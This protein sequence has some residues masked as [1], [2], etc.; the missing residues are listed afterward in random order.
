[1]LGYET[2]GEHTYSQ[3][4]LFSGCVAAAWSAL[5]LRLHNARF[6]RLVWREILIAGGLTLLML[7]SYALVAKYDA[8]LNSG[9]TLSSDGVFAVILSIM[10]YSGLRVLLYVVMALKRGVESRLFWSLVSVQ[11]EIVVVAALAVAVFVG[12]GGILVSGDDFFDAFLFTSLPSAGIIIVL[13]GGL[14]VCLLPFAA[15]VSALSVRRIVGRIEGLAVVARQMSEGDL[16][17]R[18]DVI[19]TDEIASMQQSFN[20]MAAKLEQAMHDLA[21]ERD[22]VSTLLETRRDLYAK[23]SHELRTPVTIIRSKLE[24]LQTGAPSEETYRESVEQLL[25]ETLRLQRLIDDVFDLSRSQANGLL[26]QMREL[27]INDILQE[28]CQTLGTMAWERYKVTLNCSGE[29]GLQ[30]R[31]DKQRF[32]QILVNLI[33]NALRH[34]SPGGIVSLSVERQGEQIV[35]R[36]ADTGDG[37]PPDELNRVW[38]PFYRGISDE[39]VET[40]SGLG[41]AIVHEMT[42]AMQGSVSVTSEVGKGTEFTL[43]F[44]AI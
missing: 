16:S 39:D 3:M 36:V 43:A 12:I 20:D 17:V 24:A 5:R 4:A 38:K 19:G 31:L 44:P 8:G 27:D 10:V 34:T 28:R 30:A 25:T 35:V 2:L 41:L 1:M 18:V 37:I 6:W 29:L 40:G 14:M 9:A 33:M 7:M 22:H 26:L 15:L 42:L 13:A 32:E 23:V 11:L 21:D